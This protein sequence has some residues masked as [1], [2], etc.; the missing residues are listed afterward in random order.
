MRSRAS[1]KGDAPNVSRKARQMPTASV[2]RLVETEE[3]SSSRCSTTSTSAAERRGAFDRS[4]GADAACFSAEPKASSSRALSRRGSTRA[5]R[6]TSAAAR[7]GTSRPTQLRRSAS[8]ASKVGS[9]G[10][11]SIGA[12]SVGAASVGVSAGGASVGASVGS[13]LG[14]TFV[15]STFVESAFVESASV[16]IAASVGGAPPSV[17]ASASIRL[18]AAALSAA[19]RR[20]QA[21]SQS[22]GLRVKDS[23]GPRISTRRRA[24]R[25]WASKNCAS[26]SKIRA[27]FRN[28][29]SQ[30][31]PVA[32]AG[33]RRGSSAATA[34]CTG[35]ASVLPWALKRTF[36][37]AAT[38]SSGKSS[39]SLTQRAMKS[40]SSVRA[41]VTASSSSDSGAA[42]SKA[43]AQCSS[44]RSLA[45]LTTAAWTTTRGQNWFDASRTA[46]SRTAGCTSPLDDRRSTASTHAARAA[47]R[48]NAASRSAAR[49]SATQ[50]GD[51][52]SPSQHATRKAIADDGKRGAAM[53]VSVKRFRLSRESW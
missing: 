28:V 36:L 22:P 23:W 45:K 18:R 3:S 48:A 30:P 2:R 10:A 38:K 26:S 5:S 50:P 15:G 51:A 19:S 6:S 34:R 39:G 47:G 33:A 41:C 1:R 17:G 4:R 31:W 37:A 7:A 8:V 12:A 20:A 21:P 11:T 43:A 29:A 27:A 32:S 9:V 14:S 42:P 13:A 16:F 44:N 46:L 40:E 52:L 53:T 25:R 35:P 49:P 24:T